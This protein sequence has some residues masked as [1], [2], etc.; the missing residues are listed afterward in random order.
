MD[1]ASVPPG[2]SYTWELPI[3]ITGSDEERHVDIV[4]II[5]VAPW[6]VVRVEGVEHRG[7]LPGR[8]VVLERSG[9]RSGRL[10]LAA[11]PSQMALK[12]YPPDFLETRPEEAA[13]RSSIRRLPP[14]G[15]RICE[16][17]GTCPEP[18]QD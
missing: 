10:V 1:G 4:G 14:F 18:A 6:M 8:H 9:Q 12:D 3:E 11:A 7:K 15:H 5:G 17:I 16:S 13:L 2:R